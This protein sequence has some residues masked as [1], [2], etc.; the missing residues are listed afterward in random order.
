MRLTVS[1]FVSLSLLALAVGCETS[2]SGKSPG[3]N[4]GGGS[5]GG[6]AGGSS[7]PAPDGSGVA[8]STDPAALKL[9]P[10]NT[11]IE[12]VG[13]KNDGKHNGGFKQFAG[14]IDLKG[15]DPTAARVAVEISTESIFSDNGMLTNHLKSPDFFDIK[16]HPKASFVSTAIKGGSTG[17]A[18]HTVTG[19]LTLHGVTKSVTFPATIAVAGDSA[20]LASEFT[21]NR[22]DFG[23]TYGPGKV[24]DQVVIKLSVKAPRK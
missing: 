4:A 14:T 18:T 3:G 10:E 23:M 22:Q 13:S 16:S 7:T 12:W 21:I 6:P 5:A 24:H 15:D 2:T 1:L 8:L 20:T 17:G 11:K 9:T 19:D